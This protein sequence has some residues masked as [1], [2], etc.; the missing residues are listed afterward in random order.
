M[1]CTDTQMETGPRF[2]TVR[3]VVSSAL[4]AV[5]SADTQPRWHG[6]AGERYRF[7]PRPGTVFSVVGCPVT[8]HTGTGLSGV[9]DKV[10]RHAFLF[11]HF[12][13]V[14]GLFSPLR[15]ITPLRDH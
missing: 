7:S 12:V 14:V 5:Q 4:A 8:R 13:F 2:R 3:S 10:F 6:A 15:L 11:R 9:H 1:D